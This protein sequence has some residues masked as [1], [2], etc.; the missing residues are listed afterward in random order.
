MKQPKNLT[1][2]TTHIIMLSFLSVIILGSLLLSL[3]ISSA[4]RTAVPYLDALFTATTATCVTGLVTL[5]TFSTWSAFGQIVILF[6]IQIG[7]LGVITIMSVL[8]ILLHKRMGIN[9]RLLLQDAF[10]LNSLAGIIQFVK[11]VVFGSFLVEAI[12]ALLYMFVFI[13]EFGL[14]GIWIS[15]FTSISAFCNAGIDII[16]ENSLCNYS[17]HPLINVV[18]CMLI[19]L[20]GIGYIVWWDVLHV[21][22]GTSQRKRHLFR[23]L[24]LHSKIVITSTIIL[25][26]TGAALIF[27]FEY[28]NP[29]TLQP[30]PW[31]DK[32]QL[33]LFQSVTTRTAG[34]ATIP[35]ENL[36][37]SSSLLCLILMFIGGS[38]VGTA[39]GIKTVT[40]VVLFM[41]MLAS[42]QNKNEVDIFNRTISKQAISKAVAVTSMS[43]IIM[44][45]S[46]LL[47]SLVTN[48]DVLDILY[49]TVSA[50]ATVGLTRNLTPFLNAAG[51]FVIICTMYLGRVGPL[52]FALALNSNKQ[53][54]NIIKNPTEEISV[55]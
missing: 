4:N 27:C 6:L 41:T 53:N 45:T 20:G 38:P 54:N 28:N 46:T 44:F 26:A 47:L 22:K 29:L 21:I 33:S 49:E 36:T 37:N 51:K 42:I 2:S 31:Y 17:T 40:V 52:S 3:P 39:G 50:T 23:H 8:M 5:P 35:Q 48:A 15:V 18:T 34:F 32:L 19:I 7:G 10:N 11:K 43:L 13:P 1:L 14:R 24:T 30:L 55:G 9:H 16:A 12:G 25:I